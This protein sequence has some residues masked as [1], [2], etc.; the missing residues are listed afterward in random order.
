MDTKAATK[1]PKVPEREERTSP[2]TELV[3]DV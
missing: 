1:A 3:K 2:T